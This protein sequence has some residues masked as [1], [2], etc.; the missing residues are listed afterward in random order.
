MN[1]SRHLL[2]GLVGLGALVLLTG[3]PTPYEYIAGGTGDQTQLGNRA[4]VQVISPVADLPITGG[5]PV[6]VNWT[7]VA[8]TNFAAVDIIFDVDEDPDNDNEI[9]AEES[10]ALSETTTLLDTTNLQAG[11]YNI[12]VIL[13][14][15]NEI[16]AHDY[17]DGRLIINQRTQFYFNRITC[18]T[19]DIVSP[20][21]NFVFDRTQR[22]APQFEV[23]WTLHDPDSTVTVRI[24]LDPDDTS[25][26]N[27]FLLRESYRQDTDS[28]TFNFPTA[29]FEPGIYRIMAIVSDS[30][31][32]AEF[33]APGSI[34]LRSRLAGNI[35]LRDMHLPES[36]IDGAVFEG[37][38]PRDNAGSFVGPAKDIDADGFGEFFILSQFGKPGYVVNQQRTGVGEGYLV[39]GRS[40]H[41]SGV[42]NLN[43]TGTLY[44]GEIYGGV[45]E[46]ANPIRPSRG[47]TGFTVMTDWDGDNVREFAFG[48][49]FTD[50]IPSGFL[51]E[52]GYFRSGAV[53]I[54]AGSSLGDFSGQN[55]YYL[56]DFGTM[57]V[58]GSDCDPDECVYSFVGPK[59]PSSWWFYLEHGATVPA[60]R[61]GCRISTID[62]GDQCGE[63]VA[64]YPF[65][66][67]YT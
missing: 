16:A 61:L 25:N 17:A 56:G 8:T 3:C 40:D 67:G 5:E 2:T 58:P 35:D 47:I 55:V 11:T 14:E 44:R 26:G 63:S 60:A 24:Y 37:F 15:Q 65:Y 18:L 64:A 21:D 6:E 7:I 33:Y 48:I 39:Y 42:Y 32:T 30:V 66:G 19:P 50:S 22:L 4:S 53:V 28:F 36:G 38:N 12:G 10:I 1:K 34:R 57:A 13:R 45:P 51:E 62:F 31:D 20:P 59:A 46:A 52:A 23:E 29:L 9:I 41:F 54:A 49:P 27:E 43:S